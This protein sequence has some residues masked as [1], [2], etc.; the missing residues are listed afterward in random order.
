MYPLVHAKPWDVRHRLEELG[1]TLKIVNTATKAGHLAFMSCTDNDPPFIPGTDAWSRTVR[2]LRQQLRILG[3]RK[4]DPGNYSIIIS[5]K[6]QI[7]IAVASGDEATGNSAMKPKNKSPKGYR[8]ALAVEI[9]KRQCELFPHML[10]EDIRLRPKTAEYATWLLLI[11]ITEMEIRSELSL[12]SEIDDSG[13]IVTW[14]ERIILPVI[15]TDSELRNIKS[16][17]QNETVPEVDIEVSRK[18]GNGTL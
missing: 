17:D 3:W 6:H 14:H 4:D 18:S 12:P 1:L 15:R 2:M 8:T 11:H 5:D 13:K 7:N 10:P 9:N 16:D